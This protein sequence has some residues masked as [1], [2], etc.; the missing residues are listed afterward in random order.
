MKERQANTDYQ[1]DDDKATRNIAN[2][3]LS[4]RIRPPGRH[5]HHRDHH[6]DLD[7]L[8]QEGHS[9]L[10][11]SLVWPRQPYDVK[12]NRCLR[13]NQVDLDN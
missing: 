4:L 1:L 8:V 6:T 12:S 9:M 5:A 3:D 10:G 2:V 13:P 7:P 11:R